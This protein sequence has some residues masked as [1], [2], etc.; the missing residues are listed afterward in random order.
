M[1]YT[2]QKHYKHQISYFGKEYSKIDR[3]VLQDWHKSYIQKIKEFLLKNNN[4]NITLI[5]I[6]TGHGYVAIEM[7]KLGINVIATD[8]AKEA[9]DNIKR[10]KKEFNLEN[11][12]TITCSAEKI[13]VKNESVDYIVAN[14]VLEHIPKEL[15][16]IKEWKRILKKEGRMYV[17]V[18]LRLKYIW[19]FFWPIHILHDRHIGH[20]R[21]YDLEILKK[22]F[23]LDII[24]VFYTGHFKKV[25][26]S[27]IT[28]LMHI[29]KYDRVL[30][31]IDKA[32]ENN[33]YGA[34]NIT[35]ILEK[36]ERS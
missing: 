6:G 7:A 28:G 15:E 29:N 3:Y 18:P 32:A 1:D 23:D 20:L 24:K 12:R 31:Q 30:E 36:K 17:V 9:L 2:K 8:L 14:A 4:K 25:V 35:V 13:P 5:D 16:A 11:I 19:P 10:F 33:L 34:S 21:R 27:L 22:K 26:V